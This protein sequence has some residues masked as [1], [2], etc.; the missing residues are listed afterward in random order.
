MVAGLVKVDANVQ[1]TSANSFWAA[2]TFPLKTDYASLL[3]RYF[4]AES[5]TVD[6]GLPATL[7]QINGW[8]S[9]KTDGKI[10]HM[11]DELDPQMS[12]MLINALLFKAPWKLTWEVLKDRDFTTA[13]GAKTRKEY[14]HTREQDLLYGDYGDFELVRAPYGNGAYTMDIIL[15]KEGKTLAGI[16]PTL[17]SEDIN[18]NLRSS[19]VTLYL[20]KWS[21]EYSTEDLLIPALKA[22]G[23]TLPFDPNGADFSGISTSPT[24]IDMIKQK[25]KIDV[26]EKGTEFAA[27]TVIGIKVS[28]A[29][30]VTPP[31]VTVDVN[32]P[33]AYTIR[34]STSGTIL[35][36]GTLSD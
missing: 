3:K 9:D 17:S 25:V 33:F 15:P 14:L 31:R 2:K 5:Y 22:Q 24:Y 21:T 11:L 7:K 35:L 29:M 34:E 4:A 8:C 6:F 32:R 12:L 36:L 23:L 16:L 26:T 10:P 30:P 1:F 19:K 18:Y 13:S 27:V 28:S 20:P